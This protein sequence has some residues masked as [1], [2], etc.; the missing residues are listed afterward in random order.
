MQ[1]RKNKS[2]QQQIKPSHKNPQRNIDIL[3]IATLILLGFALYIKADSPALY[4]FLSTAM[5]YVFGR[6]LA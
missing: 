1:Q 5:I 2:R 6:R 3:F 4:T